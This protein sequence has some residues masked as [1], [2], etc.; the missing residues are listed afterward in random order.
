M[1]EESDINELL[2]SFIDG[3][4]SERQKTEVQRLIA[5]DPE[6]AELLKQLQK[7]RLLVASL[8]CEQA[9]VDMAE[10]VKAALERKALLAERPFAV[11]E[12]KGA[13][14]LMFRKVFAAA[15][16]FILVAVLASVIYVI[17]AP[18]PTQPATSF[19]GRL[20]L[21][22]NNLLA[23][24][25]LISNVIRDN[26]LADSVT[27]KRQRDK[28]IYTLSCSRE[29]LS[30]FLAN[31]NNGWQLFDSATLFVGTQTP[32][33]HVV[34]K[35]VDAEQIVDLITPPKPR[36][37]GDE[38]PAEKPP[39]QAKDGKKVRLIIVIEASQTDN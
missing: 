15:A 24:D 35:D 11:D 26:G 17:V 28:N 34:I 13:R 20:E 21:K 3:E 2:N 16:M 39:V 23:V 37:T 22:T 19:A 4:M 27:L 9:P 14:H 8:P 18:G 29:N 31:L 6:V 12:R 25:G 36:L 7:C 10:Q 33:E 32:Q 1:R 30:S 38:K 5:H